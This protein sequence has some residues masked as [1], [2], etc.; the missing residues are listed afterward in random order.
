[1]LEGVQGVL[2]PGERAAA[3]GDHLRAGGA[4]GQRGKGKQ[5]GQGQPGD[6]THGVLRV[7]RKAATMSSGWS[8]RNRVAPASRRRRYSAR[9]C[10]RGR[11]SISHKVSV[12]S[13]VP[14][15]RGA[16]W[17]RAYSSGVVRYQRK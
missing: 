9:R 6:A 1:L 12:V 8:V 5:A 11:L 16:A 2:R 3:V 4:G 14:A 15:G 17:K 10:A 7:S 13:R